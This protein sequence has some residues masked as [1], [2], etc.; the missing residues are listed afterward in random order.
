MMLKCLLFLGFTLDQKNAGSFGFDK[1]EEMIRK[2]PEHEEIVAEYNKIS[3]TTSSV[4]ETRKLFKKYR[5]VN[6]KGLI[7]EN[8]S[9]FP[10]GFK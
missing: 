9:V 7:S 1:L 4:V 5:C 6:T 2:Y 10:Y 3:L 8:L